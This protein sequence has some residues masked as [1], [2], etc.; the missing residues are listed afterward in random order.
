MLKV[1]QMKMQT[2]SRSKTYDFK[3]QEFIGKHGEEVLD[4]WL[5]SA[6]KILD[7][8]GVRKYQE[9]GIDRILMRPDGTTVSVEYKFDIASSRTGNLFFE[10]VSVDNQDLPGW[11]WRS[12]ADYWIFLLPSMEVLVVEPGKMRNL[13]WQDRLGAKDKE[14]QNVGYKTLGIPISLAKVRDITYYTVQLDQE[15]PDLK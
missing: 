6:Y 13:I 9:D 15:I 7:V 3:S 11:G 10:T 2:H 5:G 4:K 14:V 1:Q 8:S 12:Q